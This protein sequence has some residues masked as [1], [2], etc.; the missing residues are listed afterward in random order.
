MPSTAIK[1]KDQNVGLGD[2]ITQY[3]GFMVGEDF[4]AV[5][6][7]DVQ[8][9]I[10]PQK[11]TS[12]PLSE[13]CIHG[14]INLRGQIVTAM[15]LRELFGLENKYKGDF[16]NVIVRHDNSLVAL[17]VDQICDVMDL[18]NETWEKT[19]ET[20]DGKLKPYVQGVHKLNKRLLIVLDLD[21]II[22]KKS[23]S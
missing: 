18:T 13:K 21:R 19:P 11:V 17:M 7:L 9:V 16:M 4:Y 3:C 14:L 12:V 5:S 20:I 15:S 8:E 6:V 2:E 10:R 23:N 22:N 1:I